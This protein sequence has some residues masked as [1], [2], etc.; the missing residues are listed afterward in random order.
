MD[1]DYFNSFLMFVIGL[2]SGYISILLYGQP[3]WWGQGTLLYYYNPLPGLIFGVGI[4]LFYKLRFGERNLSF[5]NIFLFILVSIAAF[6]VA[7]GVANLMT[8]TVIL[9]IGSFAAAGFL[10]ALI[11]CYGIHWLFIPITM[12]Q[13]MTISFTGAILAGIVQVTVILVNIV[14]QGDLR[15]TIIL[16]PV[17]QSGV[18]AAIGF[19]L[20]EKANF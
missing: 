4:I 15:D 9:F 3:D 12:R 5:W 16:F 10:G 20:S 13:K 14:L 8:I 19:M 18:G 2:I 1:R 7:V 6:L 11:L 17:W